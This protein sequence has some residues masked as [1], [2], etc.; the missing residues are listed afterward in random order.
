MSTPPVCVTP[1]ST[2]SAAWSVMIQTG[3]RHL[4]IASGGTC[5]GILDDR[6]VFAEWPMGPL[7]LRR[8]SVRDIARPC[9]TCVLPTTELR[10]VAIVMVK[11][12]IDAVPVLSAD[13]QLVGIVTSSDI[14]CAVAA[15]GVRVDEDSDSSDAL[16]CAYSS[17]CSAPGSVLAQD[18]GMGCLTTSE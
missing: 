17:A 14:A 3:L 5:V 4:V 6:A 2:V 10:M 9:T 15:H 8:R 12:S 7:A 11:N 16:Y 1:T 18:I 13:G